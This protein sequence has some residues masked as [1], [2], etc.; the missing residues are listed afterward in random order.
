MSNLPDEDVARKIVAR[1]QRGERQAAN[2]LVTLFERP[3]F[4]MALRM[5]GSPTDAADACQ[6]AFVKVCSRI[7]GFRG[8]AKVST[9][10][11]SVAVNMCLNARRRRARR[12]RELYV[13]DAPMG[14]GES[15][16]EWPADERGPDEQT[17]L[18]EVR[19]R[20]E[21]AVRELPE[22][23]GTAVLL[24]D[25]QGMAYEA[26]AETLELNVGT[27]KSRIARGRALLRPMLKDL[28]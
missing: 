26:I 21:Q 27:V 10:I 18:A 16:R 24:R 9:W 13:L 25:L 11:F 6:E 4:N 3:V 15:P 23:F 5:L 2:E 17:A 14:E 22:E 19:R 12:G 28:L 1:M 7:D 8:D 20:V